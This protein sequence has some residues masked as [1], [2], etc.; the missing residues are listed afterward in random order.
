MRGFCKRC[1]RG[2]SA[3]EFALTLPVFLLFMFGTMDYG[4]YFFKLA[5][6]THATQEGCR[7]GAVARTGGRDWR[8]IGS[9][10]YGRYTIARNAVLKGLSDGGVSCKSSGSSCRFTMSGFGDFPSAFLVCDVE[11]TSPPLV[12]FVPL[13][14]GPIRA[15]AQTLFEWQS[16]ALGSKVYTY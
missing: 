6:V 3:I 4:W 9:T 11:V 1:R 10:D 13:P 12:G 2:A 5:T 15:H 7:A 14:R 16:G 8:G